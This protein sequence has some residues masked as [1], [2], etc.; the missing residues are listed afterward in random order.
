MSVYDAIL[1][2]AVGGLRKKPVLI[3]HL[4]VSISLGTLVLWCGKLFISTVLGCP[5]CTPNF[6]LL[7][8]I[9]LVVTSILLGFYINFWHNLREYIR[10]NVPTMLDEALSDYTNFIESIMDKTIY[11]FIREQMKDISIERILV[12]VL[13]YYFAWITSLYSIDL[14]LYIASNHRYTLFG[15]MLENIYLSPA[16]FLASLVIAQF[17]RPWSKGGEEKGSS[18]TGGGMVNVQYLESFLERF[19]SFEGLGKAWRYSKTTWGRILINFVENLLALPTLMDFGRLFVI[20][21]FQTPYLKTKGPQNTPKDLPADVIEKMLKKDTIENYRLEPFRRDC[22]KPPK[23]E[24][25]LLRKAC[26]YKVYRK[27][28]NKWT[29]IGYAMLLV[30]TKQSEERKFV[31]EHFDECIRILRERLRGNKQYCYDLVRELGRMY[32]E[33]KDTLLVLILGNEELL[34]LRLLL[35]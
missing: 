4:L 35:A 33:E 3:V 25:P 24:V 22:E 19:T 17:V 28:D 12:L 5:L 8:I 20:D 26:W 30:I 14:T 31:K 23:T 1:A 18:S 11:H 21:V 7:L 29:R 6:Y 16:M 9:A 34:G 32:L 13:S 10:E 15:Y 2:S 27:K